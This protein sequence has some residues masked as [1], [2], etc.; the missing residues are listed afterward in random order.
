MNMITEFKDQKDAVLDVN[1]YDDFCQ[2][3]KDK[4]YKKGFSQFIGELYKNRFVDS[5]YLSNYIN[6]LSKNIM[7]NLNDDNTNVE[8]ASICLVQLM[9]TAIN[10]RLFK[11]N[12]VWDKIREI[13]DHPK[14]PKKL[15]FKFMDLL[16]V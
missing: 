3:N 15:K 7:D 13:K 14:L 12:K 2:K 1:D 6:A 4:I 9:E 5:T 16:G 11:N 10:R 8:N